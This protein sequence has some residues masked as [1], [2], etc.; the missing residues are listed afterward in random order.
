M[1]RCRIAGILVIFFG[2]LSAALPSGAGAE[3]EGKLV[4]FHAGSL[5]VP[6]EAM[7]KA[8]EAKYPKVDLLREPS[9][10]QKAARKVSELNWP[11][12]ITATRNSM[13]S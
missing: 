7:E 4:M 8:F 5:S 12:S 2:L 11:R 1:S 13:K 6:L 3:P 10:S 9:G